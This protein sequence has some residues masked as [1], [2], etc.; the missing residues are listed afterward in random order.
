MEKPS[1]LRAVFTLRREELP[2]ALLMFGYFFLV[3]TSFW[4]LKPVKKNLFIGFYDQSGLSLLGAH[5]DAAQAELIA[6]VLNMVV[7]FLAVVV[8]SALSERLRRQRLTLVFSGFFLLSYAGYALLLDSPGHLTVWSFYLF[9]DLFST[10]MVATFFAFLNDSV[11]PDESKRSYGLVGLGGVS[12]GVFGTTVVHELIGTLPSA[13]W[14]LVCAGLLVMIGAL[15]VA[16][17]RIV[18]RNPPPEQPRS[19]DVAPDSNGTPGGIRTPDPQVRSLMLYPAELPAR[20]RIERWIPEAGGVRQPGATEAQR[21]SR[22]AR[23]GPIRPA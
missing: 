18:D 13:Q 3:I 23:S 21:R 9:G 12:G 4:I 16:A 20:A 22:S 17:G 6:K 8:F 14:M 10:L 15:A 7:A 19:D 2:F 11:K 5:L 1:G